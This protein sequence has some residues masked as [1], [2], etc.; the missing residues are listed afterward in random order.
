MRSRRLRQ[1]LIAT[2]RGSVVA[3]SLLGYL[4]ASIGF[5]APAPSAERNGHKDDHSSPCS[6]GACGCAPDAE[7][8]CCSGKTKPAP[9]PPPPAAKSAPD[10]KP[11]CANDALCP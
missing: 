5:P 7:H 3:L 1:F 6:G 10:S 11:C 9:P 8:C 4:A 2:L